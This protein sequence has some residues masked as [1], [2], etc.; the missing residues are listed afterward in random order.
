MGCGSSCGLF[1]SAS[2][3]FSDGSGD[4]NYTSRA[5]CMWVIRI[6][7]ASKILVTFTEFDTQAGHDFVMVAQ[8]KDPACS[9]PEQL[10]VLSGKHEVLPA[11]TASA[12]LVAI[13]FKSD[14]T[15]N[16]K[17]FSGTWTSDAPTTR[18]TDVGGEVRYP[19]ELKQQV[20]CVMIEGQN[21]Y[22]SYII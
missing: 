22:F 16:A 20:F 2:G 15:D 11:I 6:P 12:G 18:S 4:A 17:G 8:C 13:A 1:T 21:F 7:Q 19:Y 10:T 3:S 14:G 5:D 9:S